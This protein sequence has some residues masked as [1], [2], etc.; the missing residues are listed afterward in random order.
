MLVFDVISG[1][2]VVVYEDRIEYSYVR[3]SCSPDMIF[4]NVISPIDP[5]IYKFRIFLPSVFRSEMYS[6]LPDS[7]GAKNGAQGCLSASIFRKNQVHFFELD[8]FP[9][10]RV[11]ILK[12][13]DIF[14]TDKFFN[15]DRPPQD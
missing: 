14:Y 2:N 10:R 4:E 7:K 13:P 8:V 12:T 15:H 11:A 9:R 6:W 1:E 5:Y 3:V